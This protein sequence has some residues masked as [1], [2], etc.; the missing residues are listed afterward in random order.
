MLEDIAHERSPEHPFFKND[1]EH[2]GVKLATLEAKL[3]LPLKSLAFGVPPRAFRDYFQM[4]E[5]MARQCCFEFDAAINR[6]Y[7]SEYLR[8]PNAKDLKSILKL[9][10]KVHKVNGKFGSIDC[11]HTWW[12]NCPKAWAGSFQEKD[13]RPSI[14]MEAISDYNL[15]FWQVSYGYCGSL[16]DLNI[17]NLSQFMQDVVTG[18]FATLE[19]EAG[20][21]PFTI[22]GEQFMY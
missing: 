12:K 21:V 4:S 10:K 16:N 13:K 7:E 15:W 6:I 9:H 3:L 18:S 5:T 20:V 2:K 22:A 19:I 8:K 11:C 17:F 14:V 1:I